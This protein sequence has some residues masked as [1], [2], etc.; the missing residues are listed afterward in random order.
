MERNLMSLR[1]FAYY[2]CFFAALF[3]AFSSFFFLAFN[4][5]FQ[6]LGSAGG[7][8]SATTIFVLLIVNL[9]TFQKNVSS[10]L[11]SFKWLKR[12]EMASIAYSIQGNI[13]QFRDAVNNETADLIPEAQVE[14]VTETTRESFFDNYKGKVIIRMNPCEDN[15][16]NLARAS[17]LQVSK[18]VI[19]ESRLYVD[20]RLNLAIDL[21]LVKK[22]LLSQDKKGAYRYF[23]NEMTVPELTDEDVLHLLEKIET[24]DGQ[25]LFTR[26][27]LRQLKELPIVSGLGFQNLSEVRNDVDKFLNYSELVAKRKEHEI[28]PLTYEGAHIKSAIMYV[29]LRRKMA[30]EGI[31]PYLKRALHDR[32]NKCEII[33]F[34]SFSHAIEFT[35]KIIGTL[36]N[37]Y[38]MELIPNSDKDYQVG[39]HKFICA[40]LLVNPTSV[41][42]PQNDLLLHELVIQAIESSLDAAGWADLHSLEG[43]IREKSP[44]F[45]TTDYGYDNLTDL[46]ETLDFLE[47]QTKEGSIEGQVRKKPNPP[48]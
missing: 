19:P 31:K 41:L 6:L 26:L 21:A 35:R 16:S 45:N 9:P 14:W 48:T 18:G 46:V 36:T 28:I 20:A 1:A 3:I 2:L 30:Y 37:S 4:T 24:I 8:I 38:G 40:M 5:L 32:K 22:M 39:D 27:F 11:S 13:N 42:K 44:S 12:A 47:F 10:I 7:F 29:A 33:F 17:F 34:I 15:D 23:V 25:G 43:K